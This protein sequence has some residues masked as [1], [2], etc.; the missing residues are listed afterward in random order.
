MVQEFFNN[1]NLMRQMNNTFLVLVPKATGAKEFKDFI[2]INLCNISYKMITNIIS[3]RII[4]VLA[5]L[6]LV[7]QGE[8]FLGR[9]IKD[10]FIVI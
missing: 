3:G 10:S 2:S 7:N 6:I 1:G 9:Q 8:F 5:N 4:N